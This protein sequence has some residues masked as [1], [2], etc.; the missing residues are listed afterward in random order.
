[1]GIELG[2]EIGRDALSNPFLKIRARRVRE[3]PQKEYSN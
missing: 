3:C 2:P 1:M